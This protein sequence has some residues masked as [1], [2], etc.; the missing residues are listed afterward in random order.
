M[1]PDHMPYMPMTDR[2]LREAQ[3]MTNAYRPPLAPLTVDETF[4]YHAPTEA[5]ISDMNIV[6]THA[7]ALAA[8]ITVACPPSADRSA[9]I[10]K[11]RECV[12]TANASIVL[13][14]RG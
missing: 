11:L 2:E 3:G 6:R 1:K 10:R 12:M 14:G 5:Q 7:K 8:A 4:D 13:G 9:A